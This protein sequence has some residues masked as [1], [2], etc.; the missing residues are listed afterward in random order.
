[1]KPGSAGLG[2]ADALILPALSVCMTGRQAILGTVEVGVFG[3]ITGH[4]VLATRQPGRVLVH[5]IGLPTT[6]EGE[7]VGNEKT[8]DSPVD[9]SFHR[10]NLI[11]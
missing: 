1:M 11:P 6:S 8:A 10:L 4:V 2:D 9:Y 5:S 7:H 3:P